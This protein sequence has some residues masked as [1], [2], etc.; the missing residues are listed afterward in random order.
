M[1]PETNT[2]GL[3]DW[4][5]QS[6][7]Q[8]P[9]GG[10]A[11]HHQSRLL[12]GR[13]SRNT[14]GPA[15]LAGP[16]IRP[17]KLPPPRCNTKA[18]ASAYL[19]PMHHLERRRAVSQRRLSLESSTTMTARAHRTQIRAQTGLDRAHATRSSAGTLLLLPASS[20]QL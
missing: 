13:G 15:S 4:M 2:V 17:V 20:T 11:L 7:V 19:P 6:S 14:P 12:T 1:K 10:S 3:A 16:H 9:I 5:R 18:T 8:Q